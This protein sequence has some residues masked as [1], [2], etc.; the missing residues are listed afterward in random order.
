MANTF[1]EFCDFDSTAAKAVAGKDILLAIF[2]SDGSKLLAIS[3]QQS[4][5]IN[6][7]AD[8]IEVN[9]KDSGGW[10]SKIAGLKE[11]TIENGGLFVTDDESHQALTSAF[12]NTDPVCVKVVNVK[13]KKSLFGG[14]AY[15][16]E[17]SIE[18]PYD[19][20]MTYSISLAGVGSLV[21]LSDEANPQ[22]P[23]GYDTVTP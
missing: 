5:T 22:M 6:R 1:P 12:D 17:Y 13:A 3:G 10:K 16:T 14:V 19:D 11:W 23:D 21:D 9:S 4:L 8:S 15:V 7:S 20:A 18:A 2:N